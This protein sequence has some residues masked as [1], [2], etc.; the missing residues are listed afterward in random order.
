MNLD[1]RIEIVERSFT[2]GEATSSD[3][4]GALGKYFQ[5]EYETTY[6]HF[7]IYYL[8]SSLIDY[9]FRF[10]YIDHY[11]FTFDDNELLKSFFYDDF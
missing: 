11:Y 7:E 10:R 4:R 5:A 6:G 1:S 8:S 2:E 9:L 3:V